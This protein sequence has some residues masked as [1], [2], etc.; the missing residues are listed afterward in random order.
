[1]V[2]R[3]VH[4]D[5]EEEKNSSEFFEKVRVIHQDFE[6][7]ELSEARGGEE[8]N[9]SEFFEWMQN[10]SKSLMALRRPSGLLMVQVL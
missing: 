5:H 7:D 4:Q 3:V 10:R 6:I 9:S 8:K 1:M 2:I